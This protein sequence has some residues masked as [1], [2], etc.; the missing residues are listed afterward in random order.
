MVLNEIA[1]PIV[2]AGTSRFTLSGE[3]V[4][5]GRCPSSQA[6]LAKLKSASSIHIRWRMTASFLATAIFAYA[7]PRR[8][9]TAS[10]QA[11]KVDHLLLRTRSECAAS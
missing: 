6:S 5:R 10:P 8:L 7:M 3:L 11:R 4:L 9:A 2:P 1:A